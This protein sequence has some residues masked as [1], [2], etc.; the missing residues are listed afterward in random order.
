LAVCARRERQCR[1]LQGRRSRRER[2]DSPLD[3]RLSR[4][5]SGARAMSTALAAPRPLVN[6]W[7]V[8]ISITFGTLMGAMYASIVNVALP[9]M[10][11]ALGA[12]LQEITWVTTGYV[13]AQV[14]VMP[15]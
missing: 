9:H 3:P 1:R 6:K 8:T 14:L 2:S 11:G 10:R 15:L 5:R 12:T 4:R 7:I 13:V